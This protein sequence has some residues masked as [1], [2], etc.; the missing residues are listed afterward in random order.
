MNPATIL[1]TARNSE[2]RRNNNSEDVDDDE[3]DVCKTARNGESQEEESKI[4]PSSD[5]IK[6]MPAD[7][8]TASIPDAPSR[9]AALGNRVRK[10]DAGTAGEDV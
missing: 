6:V 1:M 3:E 10:V 9:K 5:Q 4:L 7:E 8:E 2:G